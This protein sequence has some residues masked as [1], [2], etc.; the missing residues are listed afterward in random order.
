MR[1]TQRGFSLVEIM[2][3]LVIG[4][5]SMLVV[6]QF[7]T[8]AEARKRTTTGGADAQTAGAIALYMLER[9]TKMAGWGME[10]NGFSGCERLFTYC[11]GR[12]AACGGGAEGPLSGLT[13][14][15]VLIRDGAN[16]APDKIAVQY[17][18]DPDVST[19]KLPSN[20]KLRDTMPQ[21]SAVLEVNTT[22]GC[23]ENELMLVSQAGS[24]TL[25]NITQVLETSLKLQHNPGKSGPYNPTINYQRDNGWPAYTTG[26]RVSCFKGAANSPVFKREYSVKSNV[27][28]LVRS[29][30]TK[31]PAVVDELVM[32]DIVDLQAQYGVAN[33]GMQDVA[34][35]VDATGDWAATTPARWRRIK[36]VRVAMVARSSQYEKAATGQSCSATRTTD[37]AN[38][39]SWATF[40]TNAYPSDWGCYRYKVFETVIPLRNVIWG[41]L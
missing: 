39:S 4:M 11:D 24:C 37:V 32:A 34:A 36:A 10:M 25:M 33:D 22:N 5:L 13:F 35:W 38:W 9:D 7:F 30:N 18:S 27:R 26:A 40:R 15:P 20:A 12:N 1:H 31:T 3:G 8:N 14:A 23:R 29:D 41:I 28:Q 17:F 21:S 19:F 16:G 2:V 6:L